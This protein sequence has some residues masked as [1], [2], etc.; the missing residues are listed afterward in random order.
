[1]PIDPDEVMRPVTLYVSKIRTHGI[2][3]D[4]LERRRIT[5]MDLEMTLKDANE[6]SK[7]L[8]ERIEQGGT[9]AIR[10]RFEGSLVHG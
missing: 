2:N 4:H 5:T 7:Y 8:L 6:L 10:V 1:M 3:L 9:G